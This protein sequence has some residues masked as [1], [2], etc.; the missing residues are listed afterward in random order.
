MNLLISEIARATIRLAEAGVP[1]PRNDAEELAAHLHGVGR[2][3]LHGVPDVAFDVRFWEAVARRAAREPLQHITGR[4]FFRYVELSVGSG[5]FVPRPETEIVVGWAIEQ[6]RAMDVADPLV[7]D[8]G[9]GSAAIALAVAQEVPR[10]RVHAVELD[11]HAFAWAKLNV[12]DAGGVGER[13][14]L[15]LTE[16]AAAVPELD[17]TVDLVISNPPYVPLVERERMTPEVRDYDPPDALWAGEDGLDGVRL[18]ERVARRLLRPDGLLVVEHGDD[19]GLDVPLLFPEARGWCDVRNRRDL[20]R[21][22][23]YVT[24]RKD[25]HV[26]SAGSYPA[27]AG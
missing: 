5:V 19:Q 12:S 1:S 27:R 16:M 3:E 17:G 22:D 25:P 9:T 2:V 21:R 24:A 10:A 11:E 23:R 26:S 15:H 20:T 14:W 8:L 7:V 6:L 13:V 4:A 18:V